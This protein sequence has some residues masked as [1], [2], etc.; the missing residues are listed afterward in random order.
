[1][2][3]YLASEKTRNGTAPKIT[4]TLTHRGREALDTYT[5]ALRDL[6]GGL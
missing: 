2:A 5:R 4:V 1:M 6:L 3:G